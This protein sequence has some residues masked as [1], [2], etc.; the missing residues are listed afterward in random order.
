MASY[1]MKKLIGNEFDKVVKGELKEIDESK[2]SEF[3]FLVF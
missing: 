1:F 2:L 3:F